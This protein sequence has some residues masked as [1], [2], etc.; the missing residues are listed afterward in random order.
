MKPNLLSNVRLENMES[1]PMIPIPILQREALLN[2]RER[3]NEY[4][5]VTYFMMNLK[6]TFMTQIFIFNCPFTFIQN[7]LAE[8]S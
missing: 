4:L 3:Q 1:P 5:Y 7:L 8:I 2:V 6:M